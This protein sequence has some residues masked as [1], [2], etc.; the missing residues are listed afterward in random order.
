[1]QIFVT[2]CMLYINLTNIGIFWTPLSSMV[3]LKNLPKIEN[4]NLALELTNENSNF[5]A[6][7]L[8]RSSTYL[9]YWTISYL[10]ERVKTVK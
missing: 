5:A 9:I 2:N 4:N 6:Y 10:F 3:L 8:V 1:M 7:C